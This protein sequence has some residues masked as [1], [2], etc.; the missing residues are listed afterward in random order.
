MKPVYCLKIILPFLLVLLTALPEFSGAAQSTATLF[1]QDTATL[2][3]APPEKNKQ[4]NLAKTFTDGKLPNRGTLPP[5]DVTGSVVLRACTWGLIRNDVDFTVTLLKNDT[6]AGTTT[7]TVK[8]DG[9]CLPQNRYE[10]FSIPVTE[11][12]TAHDNISLS[13]EPSS[14]GTRKVIIDKNDPQANSL[15]F[16]VNIQPV[17][18]PAISLLLLNRD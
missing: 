18:V 11:E 7:I 1:L 14:P 2:S 9:C 13:I 17:I 15:T 6:A 3:P 4:I 16:T 8:E 12:I 10:G 5:S